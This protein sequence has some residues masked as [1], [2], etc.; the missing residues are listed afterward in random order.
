M[1]DK[2]LSE[3]VKEISIVF[4]KAM[5]A[6]SYTR[7]DLRSDSNGN[8]YMLEINPIP[9][10]FYLPKDHDSG[11]LILLRAPGG[12]AAFFE[13]VIRAAVRRHQ[14]ERKYWKIVHS[15]VRG[16]SNK[17]IRDFSINEVVYDWSDKVV[18][19]RPI[20]K[21]SEL[22]NSPGEALIKERFYLPVSSTQVIISENHLENYKFFRPSDDP[23]CWLEGL[24]L[25]AKRE[26]AAGEDLSFDYSTLYGSDWT[27][28]YTGDSSETNWK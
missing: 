6:R 19:I 2:V 15:N 8:V 1:S 10:T 20:S 12:S 26:I 24:R 22:V 27:N 16:F 14:K 3:K 18:K 13:H 11:D 5:N 17:A 7:M 28:L 9:G 25:V 4:F 21:L 23:N